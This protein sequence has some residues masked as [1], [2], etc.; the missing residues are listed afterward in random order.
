MFKVSHSEG[1]K[2]T[3]KNFL[4]LLRA[5]EDD[6][7]VSK[8]VKGKKLMY[9]GVGVSRIE[10]DFL[11]QMGDVTRADGSGGESIC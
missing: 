11:A 6:A 10:E 4:T 2:K 8:L 9:N 7:P 5:T 1:L 3:T